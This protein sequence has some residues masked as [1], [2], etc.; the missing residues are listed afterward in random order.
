MPKNDEER[1][2]FVRLDNYFK[3]KSLRIQSTNYSYIKKNK[4]NKFKKI[5]FY[6]IYITKMN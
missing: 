1:D 5:L 4:G 6:L 3:R 2:N